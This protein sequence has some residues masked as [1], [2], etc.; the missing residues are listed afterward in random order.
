MATR[1]G[2]EER[3]EPQGTETSRRVAASESPFWAL[4]AE[5]RPMG[6]R[7][8]GRGTRGFGGKRRPTR[9]P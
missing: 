3:R 9:S 6:S 5:V 8:P 7:V 2:L 4:Y 1:I